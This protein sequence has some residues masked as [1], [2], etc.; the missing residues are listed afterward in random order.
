MIVNSANSLIA[1]VERQEQIDLLNAYLAE[2]FVCIDECHSVQARSASLQVP[3]NLG[4]EQV[5]RYSL[6]L[7]GS[8]GRP[9]A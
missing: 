6:S 8:S 9:H 1:C 2:Y 4:G 3:R 7:T 5:C